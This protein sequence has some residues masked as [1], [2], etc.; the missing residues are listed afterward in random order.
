MRNLQNFVSFPE[1][2][3][4]ELGFWRRE[5]KNYYCLCDTS[6]IPLGSLHIVYLPIHYWEVLVMH[7]FISSFWCRP[8]NKIIKVSPQNEMDTPKALTLIVV[9]P[10]IH[11]NLWSDYTWSEGGGEEVPR[12][13]HSIS[14]GKETLILLWEDI[15]NAN[16]L[17]D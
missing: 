12:K 1:E 9:Y 15:N 5:G 4:K 3:T 8:L 17:E 2:S 16:Q 14:P 13:R 10:Q 6:T 11:R 7:N